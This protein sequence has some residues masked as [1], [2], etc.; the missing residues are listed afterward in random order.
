MTEAREPEQAEGVSPK[1]FSCDVPELQAANREL[2]REVD[3]LA[4]TNAELTDLNTEMSHLLDG[5]GIGAVFLDESLRIR[6]FT[7]MAAQ[8]IN[9]QEEDVGRPFLDLS[10]PAM[11]DILT[12]IMTVMETAETVERHVGTDANPVVLKVSPLVN[13]HRERSGVVIVLADASVRSETER[14]LRRRNGFLDTVLSASPSALLMTDDRG[15]ILY[16]NAAAA[17]HLATDAKHLVMLRLDS[18]ELALTDLEGRAVQGASDPMTLIRQ[19]RGPLK[20]FIVYQHR[21]NGD[22]VVLAISGNPVFGLGNEVR[23]AVFTL[24]K[25]AHKCRRDTSDV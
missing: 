15:H 18:P 21:K 5:M 22:E 1:A 16:A 12:D 20:K 2:Q 7:S 13:R 6:T 11:G 19:W 23:G 4:A 25:M 9:L 3:A 10:M 24:D 8:T 17:S 14:A